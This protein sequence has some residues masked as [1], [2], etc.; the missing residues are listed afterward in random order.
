MWFT[1]SSQSGITLFEVV[2]DEAVS[3][4]EVA[5]ILHGRFIGMMALPGLRESFDASTGRP[6]QVVDTVDWKCL[7]AKAEYTRANRGIV[8]IK[9]EET[10]QTEISSN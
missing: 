3:R 10:F 9:P 8:E 6:Y 2:G 5:R 1:L 7:K 4:A